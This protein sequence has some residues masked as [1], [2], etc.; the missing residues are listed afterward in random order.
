MF[1]LKIAKVNILIFLTALCVLWDFSSLIRVK[2]GPS[3]KKA[4]SPN[5]WPA[6]E[7]PQ[8]SN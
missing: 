4:Q 8:C 6:R 7:F 3:A 5:H 2:P 1:I